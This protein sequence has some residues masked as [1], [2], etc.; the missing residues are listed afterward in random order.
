[1]NDFLSL[2]QQYNIFSLSPT[3]ETLKDH[4]GL[5]VLTPEIDISE[6]MI[7]EYSTARLSFQL[8]GFF[9]FF[10]YK[11]VQIIGRNEFEYMKTLTEETLAGRFEKIVSYESPCVIVTRNLDLKKSVIETCRKHGIPVLRS[12]RETLD[13]ESEIAQILRVL[14]AQQETLHG[15]L[16]DVYG[17]GVLIRGD[18]GIGKS[19]AALE[20]VKRGHRLVSDDLVEIRKVSEETLVGIAPALTRDFIEVRGVGV[21]NIT[22]MFGFESVKS[23]QTIDM[24][25]NLEEY[26]DSK[27]YDRL[28][29]TPEFDEIMGIRIFKTDI[30]VRPGRNLASIVEAAAINYRARLMGYDAPQELMARVTKARNEALEKRRK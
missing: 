21:I 12:K 19:E 23:S 6:R 1:M 17:I 16:V 27:N 11:R 7:E 22:A 29:L 18:S 15:V 25:V 3:V 14:L 5:E 4:L 8:A 24:I 20:L 2:T 26:T 9:D 13:V 30:P 10:A 28:G